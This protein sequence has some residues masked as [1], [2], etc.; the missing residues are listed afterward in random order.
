[1]VEAATTASSDSAGANGFETKVDYDY[2]SPHVKVKKFLE[3]E[4][5]V[6]YDDTVYTAA[7]A[8][9]SSVTSPVRKT[10]KDDDKY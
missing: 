8:S 10:V 5:K 9:T 2:F 1:M 3:D 4:T 6:N 7:A